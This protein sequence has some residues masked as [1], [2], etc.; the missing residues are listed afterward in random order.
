MQKP[1]STPPMQDFTP[2]PIPLSQR[3]HMFRM[4]VLPALVFLVAVAGAGFCLLKQTPQGGIVGEVYAPMSYLT[5]SRDGWL[6]GQWAEV[7]DQVTAGQE[8]GRIRLEPREYTIR[9]LEVLRAEIE[10]IGQG[11]GDPILDQ[12]RNLLSLAGLRR[13]WLLARSDLA[14]L[15]VR[16]AQAAS[17]HARAAN[18]VKTGGVSKAEYELAKSLHDTLKAEETDKVALVESLA[19]SLSKAEVQD[20]E[21]QAKGLGE[22]VAAALKWREAELRRVEAELAPVVVTAPISGRVSKI[23]RWPG[24][25]VKLGEWLLEIRSDE[26]RMIVGYLKSPISVQPEVGMK[27]AVSPRSSRAAGVIAEV[28]AIG[29]QHEPVPLALMTPVPYMT[30]ERALPIQISLPENSRLKP[31]ELVDIR[32]LR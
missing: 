26:P 28:L 32:V 29:A 2:I 18:L 6:E 19:E 8:L 30:E 24:D 3:W 23:Y 21:G 15:Q 7:F 5:A 20:E 10:M 9:A 17:D 12:Q 4:R 27:V 13:D 22:G 25:S 16:I 11:T 14:S 31:G 1:T